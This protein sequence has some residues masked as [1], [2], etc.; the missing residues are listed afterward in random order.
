MYNENNNIFHDKCL[1]DTSEIDGTNMS[2]LFPINLGKI[3][4]SHLWDEKYKTQWHLLKGRGEMT[5]VSMHCHR[6]VYM[7]GGIFQEI[8]KDKVITPVAKTMKCSM[9]V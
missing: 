7:Y 3:L 2:Q 4:N 8:Y 5:N 6:T 9:S 1:L